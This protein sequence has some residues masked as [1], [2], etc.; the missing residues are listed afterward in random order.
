MNQY[1]LTIVA[2]CDWLSSNDRR[3]RWEKARLTRTWRQSAYVRAQAARLPKGLTKVRIDATLYFTTNRARDAPN[4][5]DTLKPVIDGLSRDKSR[6]TKTGRP[7]F[8]PGYGLIVDDTP[9]HLDGP[10][11]T[12]DN[13]TS[14]NGMLVLTITEVTP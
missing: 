13:T 11:I 10:H 5:T 4:Y 1:I 12:I 2:P 9:Q 8:A 7:V 3:S 14:S 6:I